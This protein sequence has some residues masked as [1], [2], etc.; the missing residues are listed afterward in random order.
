MEELNYRLSD[1]KN[2]LEKT[3]R[4]LGDNK[5]STD[6]IIAKCQNEIEK[7]NKICDD[8]D[9]II[10]NLN[11][12]KNELIGRNDELSFE[13]KNALA[14][15]KSTEDNLQFNSRQLEEANKTIAKLEDRIV[16]LEQTVNRTKMELNNSNNAH[17]K[18][19]TSRV[20]SEKNG[21]RL[22]ALLKDRNADVKKLT[23]D[24]EA[25]RINGEKLTNERNRL[26]GELDRC[27]N[28]IMVLTEQN[29]TV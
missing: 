13:L 23:A 12:D 21:E 11:D 6:V 15:L 17:A 24:L 9:G 14:K 8:Q 29:Q 28:H 27:K 1:D 20:E 18:E 22:E 26:L 10:K 19:R 25:S 7:L 16:N 3:F 5:K 4:N 2:S